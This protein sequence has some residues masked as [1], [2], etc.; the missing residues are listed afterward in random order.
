RS[1]AFLASMLEAGEYDLLVEALGYVP[2]LVQGI[3]LRPGQIVSLAVTLAATNVP[4]ERVDTVRAG[5]AAQ[6]VLTPGGGRWFTRNDLL[7]MPDPRMGLARIAA[8]APDFDGAL[9]AEG[10]PGSMTV[11]YLD[12]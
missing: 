3:R 8:L 4:P 5:A 11:L 10:L 9:G 1:G 7:R 2:R 12:G 6:P